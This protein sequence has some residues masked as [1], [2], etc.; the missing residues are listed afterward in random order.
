MDVRIAEDAEALARE[1]AA[2][3]AG[4]AGQRPDA[5]ILAATGETPI[6][7]YRELA[8]LREL[9]VLDTSRLR[10]AQLD[11]YLGLEE[12]DPRSLF[13]W[14]HRAL[15]A[16]L[17]IDAG[18][19][20]RFATDHPNA[21]LA[22]GM[23]D[24]QVDAAGGIDLAILGLGLNGHL[25]FNEPPS[26]ADAP[27]RTV[28]LDPG[29]LASNAT[30]WPNAVVP[31]RAVTAGMS[32]ILSARRVLLL[33]SGSRKAKILDRILRSAP[34]P[35]LPASHLHDHPDTIVLADRDARPKGPPDA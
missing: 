11:E 14:M 18:R 13:G 10:V 6:G 35:A 8:R 4:L 19:V 1:A 15:L 28:S 31:E 24:R 22:A 25:G 17:E 9:G 21:E 3:V 5:L 29:T 33:V 26:R 12:D 30:Y 23:Y 20:I 34:D 16:P 27:T 7:P 32:T 2:I